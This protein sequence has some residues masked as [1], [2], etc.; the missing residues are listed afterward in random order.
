MTVEGVFSARR[1]QLDTYQRDYSWT[2]SEVR[3]LVDDLRHRFMDNY[4]PAHE[5]RKVADYQPYFL[6][7]F[8][9]HEDEGLTFIVDGQQR[10][11]TLHLFLIFLQCLLRDAALDNDADNLNP[12]IKST[13]YGE[14]TFTIDITERTDLLQ[15]VFQDDEYTLP[16]NAPA[17]S[18]RL[19]EAADELDA[20]FPAELRD[21]TLPYF[22]DWLLR[23]VCMVGIKASSRE[24]GW[25]IYEGVNDRGV[26]LGPLDLLKSLLLRSVVGETSG[27][28]NQWR[29]MIT[30]LAA[31]DPNAP[32]RFLKA[33]FLGRYAETDEDAARIDELYAQLPESSVQAGDFYSWF[34]NNVGRLGIV[35]TDQYRDLITSMTEYA[36]HYCMLERA[37]QSYS[38]ELSH[39][40]FNRYNRI[41]GQFGAMLAAVN[42]KEDPADVKQKAE[43]IGKYLDLVFVWRFL[44]GRS[45][46]E[47][48]L[49]EVTWEVVPHLRA[50]P[51]ISVRDVREVLARHVRSLE[52]GFSSMSTLGLQASNKRQIRYILSRLTA[53]V[54]VGCN[55]YDESSRYLAQEVPFEI[56]HIWAN[57]FDRYQQEVGTRQAFDALRNR[58]GALV[59]LPKSDNASYNDQPFDQ[60]VAWY[61]RQNDLAASL[62]RDHRKNNAPFNS[63]VRAN[64][65]DKYFRGY[66]R[67]DTKAIS[68]RQELY[69]KLCELIWAP[70]IFGVK[71]TSFPQK[72]D[73]ATR[74]TRAHYSVTVSDLIDIG[75]LEPTQKLI[76]RRRREVYEAKLFPDGRVQLPTGETFGS[77][78]AAGQFV[79]GAKSC[80]GWSFWRAEQGDT[81][82]TLG[83]IRQKALEAGL[84]EQPTLISR[85]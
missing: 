73:P 70:E 77:L 33:F 35:R 54:A 14:S 5:R 50:V 80:Q 15:H 1:Y 56:E 7:S 82:I 37:A 72:S 76:G 66:N 25:E 36:K 8:V 23:R 41:G 22:V 3:R 71:A 65:L 24:Q 59:L 13:S 39:I 30:D 60:K 45:I 61:Q 46:A 58:L 74:R 21:E 20:I 63:F 18:R 62:H 78:S 75:A 69:R 26:R 4:R 9:Y 12:L 29:V 42:R 34:R 79:L 83:E 64:K 27:I 16:A 85:D 55:E 51:A 38:P 67:F 19:W 47:D 6:G 53:F 32:T 28:D 31:V 11:S 81:E 2:R 84:L 48:D 44:T 49:A 57:K 10:I 52:Y 68:E 43:L 40:F 17:G